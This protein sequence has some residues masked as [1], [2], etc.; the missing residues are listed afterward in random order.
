[1]SQLDATPQERFNTLIEQFKGMPEVTLGS[2]EKKGFG[3]S[4]L[5]IRGK[6]FAMLS[7]DRLVVKLPK[8]RV[9]VLVAAGEGERFDP[10][11]D[12]RLMKEWLSLSPTS[13]EDWLSLSKEGLAFVGSKR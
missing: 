13:Q 10:R 3:S 4:A 11:Q 7:H 6:I 9:D 2:S 12:G 5:Q 8:G 1:M